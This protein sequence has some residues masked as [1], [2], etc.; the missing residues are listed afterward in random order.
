MSIK[1][2]FRHII[3]LLSVSL[4]CVIPS[5]NAAGVGTPAWSLI[6]S[7]LSA[8]PGA[9]YPTTSGN[10]FEGQSV[11]VTRCTRRWCKIANSSGWLSIDHLSFGQTATGPLSGPKFDTGRGGNGNVCFFNGANFSGESICLPSGTVAHDLTLWGWDNK[12]SSVSVGDGVSVNLCRD[13]NFTSY[14]VLIDQD[15][16][17]LDHLLAN[18][19]SSYQIW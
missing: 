1:S 18:A 7:S 8:G 10:V 14:C 17:Q 13:R 4:M 6:N 9:A 16:A 11:H 3:L 12:I 5:A 19:A 15:A 2:L